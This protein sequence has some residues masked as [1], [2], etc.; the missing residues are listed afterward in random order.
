MQDS[1]VKETFTKE[2]LKDLTFANGA[3][4]TVPADCTAL[5]YRAALETVIAEIDG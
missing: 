5:S 3:L 1:P 4:L 2:D